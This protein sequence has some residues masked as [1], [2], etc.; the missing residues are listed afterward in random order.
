MNPLLDVNGRKIDQNP[1]DYNKYC[2][3]MNCHH[4]LKVGNRD[5]SLIPTILSV[6]FVKYVTITETKILKEV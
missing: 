4:R 3:N 1:K 6:L 5:V 2:T